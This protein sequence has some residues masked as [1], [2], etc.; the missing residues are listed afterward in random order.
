MLHWPCQSRSGHS[1]LEGCAGGAR[2][3][4]WAHERQQLHRGLGFG[5]LRGAGLPAPVQRIRPTVLVC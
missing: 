3:Q 1:H 4:L 5:Q 2:P